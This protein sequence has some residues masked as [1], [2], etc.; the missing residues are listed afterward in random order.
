MT[1]GTID[2]RGNNIIAQSNF[3]GN[4]D[5]TDDVRPVAV[6]GDFFYILDLNDTRSSDYINAS[7]TQLFY[8]TNMMHD[9][10]YNLGFD[11]KAGNFQ[12]VN[13]GK[14]GVQGDA[15]IVNAQNGGGMN[16]AFFQTPSVRLIRCAVNPY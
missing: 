13:N 8:T 15:V 6:N 11:E 1:A 4:E 3:N 9:L 2:T 10:L 16:N 7:T 5:I 12:Q 14:G